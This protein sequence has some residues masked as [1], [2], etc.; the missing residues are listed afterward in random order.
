VKLPLYAPATVV[1]STG[2]LPPTLKSALVWPMVPVDALLLNVTVIFSEPPERLM[3][4]V[5]S[6]ATLNA[7]P[8]SPPT[9]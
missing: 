8:L 9:V 4:N 1:L 6:V 7:C 2:K 5:G 3:S